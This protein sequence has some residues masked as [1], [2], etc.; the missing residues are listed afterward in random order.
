MDESTNRNVGHRKGVAGFDIGI[1]AAVN[2]VA[3]V[4]SDRSDNVALLAGFSLKQC[5]IS[6]TVGVVF[7]ADD[8]GGS[9]VQTAEIDY[10]IFLLVAAASVAD[11][12]LA[13]R[14]AS[15]ILLLDNDKALFGA[16]LGQF[17]EGGQ[18]HLS[19]RRSCG[20]KFDRRHYSFLLLSQFIPS[21]KAM[22]FESSVSV[23]MA[24]FHSEV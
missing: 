5:D 8:L 9:L 21:K 12:D 2:G 6:G 18:C 14:V 11:G 22:V 23:T 7:D 15:G 24:F 20:F 17:L 3:G 19:S 16:E 4:K 13:V 10:T 1:G